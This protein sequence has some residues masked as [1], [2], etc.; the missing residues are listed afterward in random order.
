MVNDC[1]RSRVEHRLM[2]TI[3]LLTF[4]NIFGM[5]T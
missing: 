3:L 1:R 2:T 4:S 5:D